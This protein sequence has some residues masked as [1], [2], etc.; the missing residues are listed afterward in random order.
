M[1]L[2][3]IVTAGG[4]PVTAGTV[5]FSDG[6]IALGAPVVVGAN[7]TAQ[8]ITS[9][10]GVRT[11]SLWASYTG[12]ADFLDSAD[13][14][15]Q[16]VERAPTLTTVVASTNPSNPG[17]SVTFTATVVSLGT[18]VTSGSVHFLQDGGRVAEDVALVGDPPP[19]LHRRWWQANT[20]SLLDTLV[21]TRT[22]TVPLTS[23]S[24]QSSRLP[25]P[26]VPTS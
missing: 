5:Q 20:K 12:S 11:H 9:A 24:R 13:T 15:N 8:L 4:A 3:A 19:G 7:G 2:T 16:V 23:S 1:T 10:L 6:G 18:P 26:G 25:S 21:M 14:V 17:E 22:R